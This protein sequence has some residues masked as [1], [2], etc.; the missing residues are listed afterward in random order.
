[1]VEGMIGSCEADYGAVDDNTGVPASEA[2][3][4]SCGTGCALTYDSCWNSPCQNGGVCVN[5]L[6]GEGAFRCE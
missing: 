4:V 2:C 1:M 6:G 5:L 3:P